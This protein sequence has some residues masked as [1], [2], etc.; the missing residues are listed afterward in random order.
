VR[1]SVVLLPLFLFQAASATSRQTVPAKGFL[2]GIVLESGSNQP[3]VDAQVRLLTTSSSSA[4]APVRPIRTDSQG[5]FSFLN[6]ERISYA[7]SVDAN[8]F[9]PPDSGSMAAASQGVAKTVDLSK[10]I[11]QSEVS[12]YLVRSGNA[13]GRVMVDSKPTRGVEVRLVQVV[14]DASGAKS[15]RPVGSTVTDSRGDFRISNVTPGRYY[16]VAV[17]PVETGRNFQARD[18]ARAISTVADVRYAATFYPS[19]V[20]MA[21]AELVEIFPGGELRGLEFTVSRI[22]T[23]R[24]RGNVVDTRFNLPATD[25]VTIAWHPRDSS[26]GQ[27]VENNTVEMAANGT[28]E[29]QGLLT[30]K[31]WL[32]IKARPPMPQGSAQQSGSES[33]PIYQSVVPVDIVSSNVENLTVRLSPAVPIRGRITL[34]GEPLKSHPGLGRVVVVATPAPGAA[35]SMFMVPPPPAPPGLDGK[36]SFERVAPGEYQLAVR[37]L[38]PDVYVKSA[39][40][41][42]VDVLQDG[43]SVAEP[44]SK[45][46]DIVL[47]VR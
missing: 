26:S 35:N 8:G 36:F 33:Q 29:I 2:E 21:K 3:I 25:H 7:I 45:S 43:L 18:K 16:A 17:P 9:S 12:I 37:S 14:S 46:L 22:P 23:Y 31:Y 24:I 47:G 42:P 39:T 44:T 4:P 6:L 19:T 27:V 10:Q 34:D 11:Y 32:E 38:P 40:L 13:S 5:R 1:V 41:G 20:D 28:F 15:L 30:G